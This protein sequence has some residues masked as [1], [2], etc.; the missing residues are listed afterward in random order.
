[1]EGL[2]M[3]IYHLDHIIHYVNNLDQALESFN[4][5]GLHA[6][7][8]GSHKKWG[9]HNALS[10]FDLSYVEFLAIE[11]QNKVN[12]ASHSQLLAKDALQLLPSKE[13][14]HRIAIRTNDIEAVAEKLKGFPLK[15]SPILEGSRLD[16]EGRLIEWKMLMIDGEYKGV[17]YPFFIQWK[18]T[19]EERLNRLQL[20]PHSIEDVSMA[21]V[22]YLVT[23]PKAVA[24]HWHELFG[25]PIVEEDDGS[26]SLQLGDVKLHFNEGEGNGISEV[27]FKTK[28]EKIKGKSLQIGSGNYS[29]F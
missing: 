7:Y 25:F 2:Q 28:D 10:Y 22:V 11:D 6:F 19:D 18:E 14:I 15:V 13:V 27:A 5:Y 17:A 21:A 16:N 23:N 9:T 8:G 3:T 24:N 4:K 29:F 1:M 26:Y 20:K 12:Q